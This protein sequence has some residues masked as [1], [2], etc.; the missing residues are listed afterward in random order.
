MS[1][2]AVCLVVF[3]LGAVLD[4]A[5]LYQVA[6]LLAFVYIGSRLWSGFQFRRLEISRR[7]PARMLNGETMEV[8]LAIYNRSPLPVPWLRLHEYLPIELSTPPFFDRLVSLGAGETLRLRYALTGRQRGYY[9]IGPLN[10]SSGDPFGFANIEVRSIQH[11][12][13]IVYPKVV[14]LPELGLP[15]RSPFGHLRTRYRLYEDPSR[16]IGVRDYIAGDSLRLVNWKTSAAT[17][18]LK[19]RTL[20]PAM[21][22]ET[23]LLVNLNADEYQVETLHTAVENAI[24]ASA[25]IANYLLSLRQ[26]VALMTNGFDVRDSE[27]GAAPQAVTG[28]PMRK[29]RS[30]LIQILELLACLHFLRAAPFAQFCTRIADRIP[31]G[32]TIGL[33]CPR[34]TDELLRLAIGFARR[35]HQIIFVFADYP[36]EWAFDQARRRTKSA[37]FEAYRAWDEADLK[38][39]SRNVKRVG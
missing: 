38:V 35:G 26:Q 15:S 11:Q 23:L 25:S 8:E 4:N 16:T 12:S 33:V 9:R 34:L 32:A 24:T 20:E 1:I 36:G 27:H 31:W 30:H 7:L 18:S 13:L 5:P 28:L 19:I 3:I 21:T 14:P 2:L 17:G 39:W 37:G 29:G 6:Y 22:L 10:M